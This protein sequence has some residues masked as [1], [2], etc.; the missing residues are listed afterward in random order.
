[1][2]SLNLKGYATVLA[3]AEEQHFKRGGALLAALAIKD[4]DFVSVHINLGIIIN[5]PQTEDNT[6]QLLVT[7]TATGVGNSVDTHERPCGLS[8]KC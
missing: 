8:T 4:G 3:P 6:H 2:A 7:T 5:P 1:M